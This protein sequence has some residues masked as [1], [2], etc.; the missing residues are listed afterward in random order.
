VKAAVLL[1]ALALILIVDVVASVRISGS[2]VL[3]PT[4]KAAWL[5]LVWL[6]PL[7]GAIFAITVTR[8]LSDSPPAPGSFGEPPNPGIEPTKTG[9]L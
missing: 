1:G 3:L 9:Y 5:V 4:Q 8:E 6:A 2:K 7:I